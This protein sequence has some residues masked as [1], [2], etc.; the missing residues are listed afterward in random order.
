MVL[1]VR[2]ALQAGYDGLTSTDGLNVA[3]VLLVLNLYYDTVATSFRQRLVTAV[4]DPGPSGRPPV[5]I[6]PPVD[7]EALALDLPLTLLAGLVLVG[8]VGNEVLRFWGIRLFAEAGEESLGRRLPVLLAAAGGVALLQFTLRG[9]LPVLWV[10]GD[11]STFALASQLLGAVA[12]VVTVAA[13]YLRQAVALTAAGVGGVFRIAFRSLRVAPLATLGV[14][15]VVA[16]LRIAAGISTPLAIIAGFGGQS[17]VLPWI[18]LGSLA[19]VAVVEA[20]AIAAVTDAYLQVRG[21]TD[22][23]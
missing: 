18:Q 16:V 2:R 5:R 22:A 21:G 11:V 3:S 20:F 1:D 14:L 13:V 8:I 17:G 15:A 10:P 7:L 9:L 6:R 23:A 4:S 12:L 19:L